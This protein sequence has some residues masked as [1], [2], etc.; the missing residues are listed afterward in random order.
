VTA[1][2]DDALDGKID[3]VHGFAHEIQSLLRAPV[4][5]DLIDVK[6]RPLKSTE[7]DLMQHQL[8]QLQ[9]ADLF[10][11]DDRV[12]QMVQTSAEK[13]PLDVPFDKSW[14]YTPSGLW[15]FGRH[16]PRIQLMSSDA[17]PIRGQ[18]RRGCCALSFWEPRE[19]P[20]HICIGGWSYDHNEHTTGPH[21]VSGV[22]LREGQTLDEF[23]H[24]V[25][26]ADQEQAMKD[27][28][29]TFARLRELQLRT[30]PDDPVFAV[31]GQQLAAMKATMDFVLGDVDPRTDQ[32]R[33]TYRPG[34]LS[35]REW[36]Q[37]MDGFRKMA[38]AWSAERMVRFLIAGALWIQQD[39]VAT[40]DVSPT[41]GPRKRAER[42]RL[43]PTVKVVEL[44]KRRYEAPPGTDDHHAV[45]WS[46]SWV[47]RGH[48]RKQ[49]VK[50]GIKLLWI[51]PYV[52][53]DTEKPL[54][55]TD[56]IFVVRR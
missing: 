49:P 56:R 40:R 34:M 46:C 12:M 36:A 9:R 45:E 38:W 22:H 31:I 11:W 28:S 8:T 14:L 26:M 41:R 23:M 30:G 43:E 48:W 47:V 18:R 33:A 42:V 15:W 55:G 20:G 7:R 2:V 10:A 1:L 29:A 4:V 37:A 32:V 52:K 16:S 39:V 27:A 44:R 3:L 5:A 17:D 53:G 19:A 25:V 54:K 51:D 13:L 21:I 35:Q 24:D 6:N 50:E